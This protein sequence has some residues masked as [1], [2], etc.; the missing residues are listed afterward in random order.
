MRKFV[1]SVVAIML[2]AYLLP[3]IEVSGFVT[4]IIIALVW[5]LIN[6]FIKPV[7]TLLTLPV[8]VVTMGLFLLFI[9]TFM[10]LLTSYFVSGFHIASFWWA[11]GFSFVYSIIVSLVEEMT[12]KEV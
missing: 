12:G 11:F 5:S 4:A 2:A 9:N 3:G 10:I 1:V 6:I 7:F 8:T